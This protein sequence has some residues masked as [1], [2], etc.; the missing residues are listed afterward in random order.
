MK[1]IVAAFAALLAF[2][3]LAYAEAPV[4]PSDRVV[5]PADVVPERYDIK[6]TPN[7]QSLTFAGERRS[8]S[9]CKRRLTASF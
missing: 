4:S 3:G 7:A 8:P 9:V 5:L 1:N 2:T 6:V